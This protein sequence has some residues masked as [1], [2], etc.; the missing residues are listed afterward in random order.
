MKNNY[1]ILERT[2]EILEEYETYANWSKRNDELLICKNYLTMLKKH[3]E[4]KVNFYSKNKKIMKAIAQKQNEMYLEYYDNII[5]KFNCN[6]TEIVDPFYDTCMR[7]EVNPI[8]EYMDAFTNSDWFNEKI[9]LECIT[10]YN[11]L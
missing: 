9:L 3:I 10:K 5:I 8:N 2:I 7:N 11:I 1:E 4:N 6:E